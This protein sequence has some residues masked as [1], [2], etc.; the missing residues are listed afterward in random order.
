[1]NI[2]IDW[3]ARPL[4]GLSIANHCFVLI[5]WDENFSLPIQTLSESDRM[6]ITL[7]AFP[8]HPGS[9]L[10]HD[11]GNMIF[12][13]NQVDDVAKART[14]LSGEASRTANRNRHEVEP[15]SGGNP[16][17][18][19]H[20]LTQMAL[21]YDRYSVQHPLKYYPIPDDSDHYTRSG[22]RVPTVKTYN[23]NGWV[24]SLF[25][26]AGISWARRLWLRQFIGIDVGENAE[27]PVEYFR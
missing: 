5:S 8:Q 11:F 27:I 7:G 13:A 2:R 17:T 22:R 15:P 24:N 9:S 20:T 14:L 26:A 1:M 23:S 25:R 10:T 21:H 16:E 3:V 4:N 12:T 19:A 18:F 6:F